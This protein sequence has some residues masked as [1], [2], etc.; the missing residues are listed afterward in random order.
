MTQINVLGN[1]AELKSRLRHS[2]YPV[3]FGLFFILTPEEI[4]RDSMPLLHILQVVTV[5]FIYITV[6]K[7]FFVPCG[8]Q[9]TR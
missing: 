8:D 3:V 7:I 6:F 9:H 4:S 1:I 5:F 2:H